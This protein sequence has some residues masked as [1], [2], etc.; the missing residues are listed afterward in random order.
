[1][2]EKISAHAPL[3]RDDVSA[4][5]DRLAVTARIA[6]RRAAGMS[7]ARAAELIDAIDFARVVLPGGDR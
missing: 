4:A 7:K 6:E 5:L 2:I 3:G 1:M